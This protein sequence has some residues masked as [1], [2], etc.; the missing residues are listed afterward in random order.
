MHIIEV[1]Q[2]PATSA[3]PSKP[4]FLLANIALQLRLVQYRSI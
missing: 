1:S 4:L 2:P 3:F